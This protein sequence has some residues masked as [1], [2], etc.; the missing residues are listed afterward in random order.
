M[1][2]AGFSI[3]RN[4]G[5]EYLVEAPETAADAFNTAA[6]LLDYSWEATGAIGWPGPLGQY[7]FV[8]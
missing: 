5:V 2:Q 6:V 8:A 7:H 1:L 3:I 4:K